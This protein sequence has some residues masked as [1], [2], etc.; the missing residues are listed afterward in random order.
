MTFF[1]ILSYETGKQATRT[2]ERVLKR[3]ADDVASQMMSLSQA[4]THWRWKNPSATAL[5][6]VSTLGLPF[7]TPDSRIGYA[8]SGGRLWVW[9]AED[10]TPGLAARLT[11][12]HT[13]LRPPFP[14]QQRHPEGHAGQHRQHLRSDPTLCPAV[15]FRHPAG[16]PQLTSGIYQCE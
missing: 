3:E 7:S 13:R 15:H 16:S 5:P 14:V 1:T 6:A 10:S 11:T 2:E 8:L 9:S 12:S 4:L